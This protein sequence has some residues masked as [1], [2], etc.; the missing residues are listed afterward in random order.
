MTQN[1]SNL[2]Y[3]IRLLP[4]FF[5]DPKERSSLPKKAVWWTREE[6][7]NNL[8]TDIDVCMC[9][10]RRNT[11]IPA[12]HKTEQTIKKWKLVTEDL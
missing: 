9:K 7:L 11:S 6:K 12:K 3:T 5:V 1:H 8:K 10:T 2:G 4:G